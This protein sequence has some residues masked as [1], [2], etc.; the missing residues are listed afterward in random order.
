VESNV[1]W[2]C[3]DVKNNIIFKNKAFDVEG[4]FAVVIERE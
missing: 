2:Y 4:V 1:N 3:V